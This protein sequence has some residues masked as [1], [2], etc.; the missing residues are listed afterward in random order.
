MEFQEALDRVLRLRGGYVCYGQK[1]SHISPDA[2]ALDIIIEAALDTEHERNAK[3][4][5]FDA[6]QAYIKWLKKNPKCPG[7]ESRNEA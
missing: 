6:S 3:E 5:V 4:T 1:Q 2:I 7:A